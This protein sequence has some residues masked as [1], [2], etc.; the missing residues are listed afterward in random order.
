MINTGIGHISYFFPSRHDSRHE[1]GNSL[2]DRL[3]CL[4]FA[5]ADMRVAQRHAQAPVTQ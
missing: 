4:N 5:L 1:P 3:R 2:S